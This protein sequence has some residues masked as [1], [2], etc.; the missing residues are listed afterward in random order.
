MSSINALQEQLQQQQ[1]QQ[2][3]DDFPIECVV[4]YETTGESRDPTL[5]E[6][7]ELIAGS[8]AKPGGGAYFESLSQ[9]DY[10]LVSKDWHNEVYAN[11]Y[12]AIDR[13]GWEI[14]LTIPSLDVRYFASGSGF[15]CPY[16]GPL[17]K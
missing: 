14:S 6:L 8:V 1:Q 7:R 16:S 4:K 5:P 11:G 17:H 12:I 15:F 13:M 3:V 2:D 9:D 10:H